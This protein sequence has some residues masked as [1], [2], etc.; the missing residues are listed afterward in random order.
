MAAEIIYSIAF[1]I[2]AAVAIASAIL[3]VWHKN[4]VIN[5]LYLVLCLFAVAVAYVLLDAHFL[6]AIQVLL[7]AGAI[8]VLFLMIVMLVNVDERLLKAR[9]TVGK[10]IGGFA[11]LGVA[12][13][14]VIV[15][16]NYHD[17]REQVVSPV[18]MG[19]FLVRINDTIVDR[20]EKEKEDLQSRLDIEDTA[21][22][23]AEFKEDIAEL[24]ADIERRRDKEFSPSALAASKELGPDK[25]GE[26]ALVGLQAMDNKEER[27][28]VDLPEEVDL[29]R[30]KKL[31]EWRDTVKE[32]LEKKGRLKNLE[33]P[34]EFSQISLSSMYAYVESAVEGRLRYYSE[35]GSTRSV[36]IILFSRHLLPFELASILLLG[37]IIG[38]LVLSR[39]IPGGKEQ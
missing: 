35:F 32:Q 38:A 6:A 33:V 15:F 28:F 23:K 17:K 4:P 16:K 9:P 22:A 39:R 25:R 29:L 30:G 2:T 10:V 19:G 26:L 27:L 11:V 24:E 36:G 1:Y 8:L 13:L 3:V 7:Y 21:A 12:L 31:E 14:L 37:A 5:A 18:Q 34:V 20:L